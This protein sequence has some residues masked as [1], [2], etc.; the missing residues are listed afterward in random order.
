MLE[1]VSIPLA[2]KRLFFFAD[3]GCRVVVEI[4]GQ[5]KS[6]VRRSVRRVVSMGSEVTAMFLGIAGDDV[7]FHACHLELEC[8]LDFRNDATDYALFEDADE[9]V[10]RDFGV[11]SLF[12][13]VVQR[14][15]SQASFFA[16]EAG[17]FATI[18]IVEGDQ[19]PA[20]LRLEDVR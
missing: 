9:M 14:A 6:T 8:L 13:I 20:Q 12:V 7:A 2:R 17:I 15:N 3:P 11:A 5:R 10:I 18:L 19:L 1:Y 4:D 16:H